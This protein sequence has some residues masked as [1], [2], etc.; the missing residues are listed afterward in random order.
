M[1][2]LIMALAVLAFAAGALAAFGTAATSSGNGPTSATAT[3]KKK[4]PPLPAEVRQRKRWVIGVKCDAPPFGYINVKGQNAGFDVEI[5]KWFSRFAFGRE[6]R[7]TYTCAPTPT[8][9]PLLTNDRADLVIATF[10]YNQD[11]DTR[12]DFS[13]AYYQATGRLLIRNDSPLQ[14]LADIRGRTVATTSSSIYDRWVRKC[15]TDAKLSVFD[16]FT[17]ARIAFEQGRADTLM[18]D[19][20]VLLGMAT[21]DPRYKLAPDNFLAAPYGIGIKQGNV[22]MKRWVDSRLE[23]MRKRDQFFKILK[24]NVAGRYVPIF[25]QNILRP[26]ATFGYPRVDPATV[27]P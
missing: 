1:K 20:T 26:K 5:A 10:T 18:W 2:R 8:R 24:N 4:L 27:C 12:I 15:F 17:N 14:R 23:I 3:P 7:V 13:R 21:A 11:R 16:N 6:S 25:A 22:A 9:E 19:D